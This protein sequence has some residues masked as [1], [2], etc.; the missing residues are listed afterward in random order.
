MAEL[1]L[2]LRFGRACAR[3]PRVHP[4]AALQVATTERGHDEAVNLLTN[5]P[6][7]EVVTVLPLSAFA[8]LLRTCT[9]TRTLTHSHTHQAEEQPVYSTMVSE[10]LGQARTLPSLKW[11]LRSF[12]AL[13]VR[14]PHVHALSKWLGFAEQCKHGPFANPSLAALAAL[15]QGKVIDRLLSFLAHDPEGRGLFTDT[16][17]VRASAD[18]VTHFC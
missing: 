10:L 5:L 15:S 2:L 8:M 13:G 12:V 16:A 4:E 11:S 18:E 7:F 3:Y 9:H 14:L 1:G 6:L 17:L